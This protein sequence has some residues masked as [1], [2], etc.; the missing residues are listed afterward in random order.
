MRTPDLR[1]LLFWPLFLALL[2]Q[3][4]WVRHTAASFGGAPGP[5]SGQ[6]GAGPIIRLVG[7]GDSI[8]DGV[9]CR[10]L[11]NALIGATARTLANRTASRVEW[12]TLG[13]SGL[14]T[15]AIR[16]L[17]MAHGEFRRA[18]FVLVSA[19]VNDVTRLS[20]PAAFA[21]ELRHLLQTLEQC[22]PRA[23]IVINGLPPMHS[24]PALPKPL[25]QVLGLRARQLDDAL[26]R[27]VA[28]FRR[29]VRV[30]LGDSLSAGQFSPDGFHPS[31]QACAELADE[32][33]SAM[34]EP[35]VSRPARAH[36]G[37]A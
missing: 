29:V 15:R 17:L 5:R 9:G 24:F 26:A 2:P 25:N 23:R 12:R 1:S 14:T 20:G 36:A 30:P 35:D 11:E 10:S 32:I 7:V 6:V 37:R 4:L 34:L 3:A 16:R 21:S 8:I 28:G 22:A 33:V 31:E 19:G 18:D 13:Q 27:V